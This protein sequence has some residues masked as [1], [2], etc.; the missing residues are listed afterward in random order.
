MVVVT[1]A[2]MDR[3]AGEMKGTQ[4]KPIRILMSKEK[5]SA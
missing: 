4:V 3:I 5:G 2:A 1:K